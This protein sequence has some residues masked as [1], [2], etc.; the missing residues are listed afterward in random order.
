MDGKRAMKGIN[1]R[2]IKR[3]K[4]NGLKERFLK[5]RLG[6]LVEEEKLIELLRVR[7][8]L[9]RQNLRGQSRSKADTNLTP[10]GSG[11]QF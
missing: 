11:E 5:E 6:A 3:E 7:R 9:I 2:L 10:I 1:I 4:K 8:R